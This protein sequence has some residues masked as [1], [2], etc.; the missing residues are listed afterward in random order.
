VALVTIFGKEDMRCMDELKR[1]Y[2]TL[3]K[4]YNSLP[5][6]LP[7]TLFY[8]AMKARKRL[9]QI[10]ADIIS[11]KRTQ[12][13]LEEDKGLLASLIDPKEALTDDQIAD[14]IIG[15]IFA[16]RDTTASVLTWI[17]KCLAENPE[18]LQAV[19]V[20]YVQLF[21]KINC[22]VQLFWHVFS[23]AQDL[24]RINYNKSCDLPPGGA[25]GDHKKERTAKGREIVN[26]V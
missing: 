24:S 16:A 10:V 6:N 4:G 9:G 7:G 3:E 17:V 15:L 22:N 25:R 13:Q 1:C 12:Q 20:N 23:I 14:N 11:S 8:K 19:K 21:M 2:Y 18:I 5:I 26:M